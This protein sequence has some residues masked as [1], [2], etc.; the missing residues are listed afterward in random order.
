MKIPAKEKKRIL[1]IKS[2]HVVRSFIMKHIPE[3]VLR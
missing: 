3:T 1:Q 2:V